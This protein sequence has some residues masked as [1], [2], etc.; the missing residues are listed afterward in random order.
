MEAVVIWSR[1]SIPV[2]SAT[3]LVG[4]PTA[5]ESAHTVT[6]IAKVLALRNKGRRWGVGS[7][8]QKSMYD[9]QRFV[10][11]FMCEEMIVKIRI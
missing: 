2:V 1:A 7:G 9:R 5:T 11:K 8:Q 3:E 10:N 4:A 6:T